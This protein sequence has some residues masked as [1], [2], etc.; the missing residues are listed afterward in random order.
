MNKTLVEVHEI[1][2]Y[3][4]IHPNDTYDIIPQEWA[5]HHS[6]STINETIGKFDDDILNYIN[7]DNMTSVEVNKWNTTLTEEQRT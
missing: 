2:E 7:N 3:D 1:I 4:R 5:T 6:N